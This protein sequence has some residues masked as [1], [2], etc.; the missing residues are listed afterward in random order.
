MILLDYEAA[1]E[2]LAPLISSFY[3]FE[4]RGTPLAELERADRA[5]FRFYLHGEGEYHFSKDRFDPG[6]P[7]TIVGPTTAPCLTKTKG[8]VLV[9]GWG[10]T[11]A[12]WAALM[13]SRAEKKIDH[14]FD[15]REIFG[16]WIMDLRAQLKKCSALADQ[17][18]LAEAAIG[19]I[20]A[21]AD[22]APFE[23]TYR[24]DKW[25]A[26]SPDPQVDDLLAATGLSVRQLERTTKRYYGMPP[27]KLARK[28]RAL[29]AAHALALGD[30]LDENEL[31]AAF[32]DQSHLIREIKQFTGL[33]PG[34]LRSGQSTL[35]QATMEGR[36]RMAGKVNPLISDS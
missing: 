26:S 31:G 19:E 28:Y 5:Q 29:R 35:T 4:Y 21:N 18:K 1:N 13:G 32:Y 7:V 27:K 23:F 15:A 12:G 8:D 33:T 24:V 20:Y 11:P 17:T 36:S 6:H 2:K 16:D 14:A 10:I 9:F 34:Q 22:K 30:S 3:R 25:L